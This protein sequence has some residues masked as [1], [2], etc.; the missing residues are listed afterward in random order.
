QVQVTN[1]LEEDIIAINT[2]LRQAVSVEIC[3]ANPLNE[4]LLFQVSLQGEGLLG[5]NTFPLGPLESATYTLYYSPM[6]VQSH[7]GRVTFVADAVGEFW[8]R[9]NLRADPA[10]SIRL[11]TIYCPVGAREAVEL[12][13]DNPMG[14]EVVLSTA[15]SSSNNRNFS[16]EPSQ[17]PIAPYGTSSFQVVYVPSSLGQEESTEIILSHPELGDWVYDVSGQGS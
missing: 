9:L 6:R 7:S 1:P 12:S 2:V 17:I 10:P 8:Y 16:V 11:D 5:D 15:V 14:Q 3:L 13:I 4:D